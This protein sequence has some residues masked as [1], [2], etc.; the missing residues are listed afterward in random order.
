MRQKA[1]RDKNEPEIKEALTKIGASVRPVNDGGVPDLL[2][3]FRDLFNNK[4]TIIMEVKSSPTAKLTSTQKA[5]KKGWLGQYTIVRSPLEAVTYVQARRSLF[6]RYSLNQL[7]TF[8]PENILVG[9]DNEFI[10]GYDD[11]HLVMA[12]FEGDTQIIYAVECGL[13]KFRAFR[14]GNTLIRKIFQEAPPGYFYKIENDTWD[15]ISTYTPQGIQELTLPH[16]N[17]KW[18]TEERA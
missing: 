8:L 16:F 14:L 4:H 11:T 1:K 17:R 12:C 6:M 13:Q 18:T 9:V 15:I 3:G 10:M 5:W 7:F 2:V